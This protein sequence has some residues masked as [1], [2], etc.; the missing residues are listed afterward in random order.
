M[1]LESQVV[2][3]PPKGLGFLGSLGVRLPLAV[4]GVQGGPSFQ[5][6]QEVP[7]LLVA[8][9]NLG[10]LDCLEHRGDLVVLES[11]E[12]LFHR[13][14]QVFLGPLEIQFYLLCLWDP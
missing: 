10:H 7:Y 12:C 5:L 6:V 13:N 4:L 9:S 8:L 2:H 14:G 11:L 1:D 3:L